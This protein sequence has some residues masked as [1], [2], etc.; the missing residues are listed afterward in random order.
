MQLRGLHPLSFWRRQNRSLIPALS[1]ILADH[2]AS[3]HHGTGALVPDIN[4]D[5]VARQMRRQRR[6]CAGRAGVPLA[7]VSCQTPERRHEPRRGQATPR[8]LPSPA[9]PGRVRAF[10]TGPCFACA[11]LLGDQSQP[12]RWAHAVRPALRSVSK[13]VDGG[14]KMAGFGAPAPH[15]PLRRVVR[16]SAYA[17]QGLLGDVYANA[18]V[19]S[20]NY[21][22]TGRIMKVR[23]L[24]GA[25]ARL[26]RT[27]AAS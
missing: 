11:N 24:P 2:M 7:T 13:A 14:E 19:L 9:A 17:K 12:R 26:R 27:L 15:A 3:R 8:P 23:G 25:I 20:E 5:L 4:D 21:D 1:S 10:P 18:R 6:G 16:A 22:S